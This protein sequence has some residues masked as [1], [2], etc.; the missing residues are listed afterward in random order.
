MEFERGKDPKE[1]LQIGAKANATKCTG[2]A[3]IDREHKIIHNGMAVIVDKHYKRVESSHSIRIL[4]GIEA[5]ELNPEDY[6]LVM[7]GMEDDDFWK[8]DFGVHTESYIELV[9]HLG[10][11]VKYKDHIYYIPTFDEFK[12]FHKRKRAQGSITSGLSS[13]CP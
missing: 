6:A 3:E 2:I 12:E 9:D 1:A 4:M 8:Q 5:M 10:K 11:F 13:Q 7:W